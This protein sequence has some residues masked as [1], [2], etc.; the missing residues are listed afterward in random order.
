MIK[1]TMQMHTQYLASHSVWN[2]A[3]A[4]NKRISQSCF[5]WNV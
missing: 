2:D 1:C 4:S 5:T 3:I